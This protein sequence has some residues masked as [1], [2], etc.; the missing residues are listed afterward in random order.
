MK[1]SELDLLYEL[2]FVDAVRVQQAAVLFTAD[3]SRCRKKALRGERSW[4]WEFYPVS[5]IEEQN[6]VPRRKSQ[7]GIRPESSQ[8]V[9]KEGYDL[10]FINVSIPETA[11]GEVE[12]YLT[13]LPTLSIQ[14][15]GLTS[16]GAG[17]LV[18]RKRGSD[19]WLAMVTFDDPY[20]VGASCAVTAWG[21]DPASAIAAFLYK[22]QVILGGQ[23][24]S[25]DLQGGSARKRFG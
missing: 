16:T 1:H 18:K 8:S 24:P 9:G 19:D 13:D 17:I 22:W 20:V 7:S 5:I 6:L 15:L 23:I 10:R 21:A 25:P 3:L 4:R 2:P 12:E 14:F 11:I